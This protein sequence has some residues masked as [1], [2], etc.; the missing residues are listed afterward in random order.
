[1]RANGC[2][3]RHDNNDFDC[4]LLLLFT[5]QVYSNF[6]VLSYN[7]TDEALCCLNYFCKMKAQKETEKCKYCR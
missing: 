1:M 2:L 7:I 6:C 3:S 5:G 4:F